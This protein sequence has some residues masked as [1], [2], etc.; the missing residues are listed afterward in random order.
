MELGSLT[1][2]ET[3][4]C[5]CDNW[6]TQRT[7]IKHTL[8][9]TCRGHRMHAQGGD[10]LALNHI[11]FSNS[12]RNKQ[13]MFYKNNF[14]SVAEWDQAKM[15]FVVNGARPSGALQS[16]SGLGIHAAA[17]RQAW[18]VLLLQ[19]SAS[20]RTIWRVSVHQVEHVVNLGVYLNAS[21]PLLSMRRQGFHL[22]PHRRWVRTVRTVLLHS[23]NCIQMDFHV[24]AKHIFKYYYVV[25][26]I[27][28]FPGIWSSTI[29]WTLK[30]AFQLFGRFGCRSSLN[31]CTCGLAWLNET[32]RRDGAQSFKYSAI[33][34]FGKQPEA[35]Y[36]CLKQWSLCSDSMSGLNVVK[37]SC[38]FT[39]GHSAFIT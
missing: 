6:S 28:S 15:G 8:V 23:E 35:S 36:F 14:I 39:L 26:H 38:L 29:V 10:L 7:Q 21:C 18:R 24:L 20:L 22:H 31:G 32:H 25:E 30:D 33:F 37:R 13:Q 11:C 4:V 3:R 9:Y 19:L 34:L 2:A 1:F 12:Q 16:F 5:T 27:K 17:L